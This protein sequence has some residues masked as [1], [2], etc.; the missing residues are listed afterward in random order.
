MDHGYI[1]PKGINI[2]ELLWADVQPNKIA[3][4]LLRAPATLSAQISTLTTMQGAASTS[5]QAPAS[6][7]ALHTQQLQNAAED[8]PRSVSDPGEQYAASHGIAIHMQAFIDKNTNNVLASIGVSADD[9]QGL[10]DAMNEKP[11]SFWDGM[12]RMM[13][14]DMF[15]SADPHLWRLVLGKRARFRYFESESGRSTKINAF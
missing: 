11:Q 1:V 15:G 2:L 6:L 10:W 14:P 3:G 12:V 8:T 4:M 5:T 9:E 13:E 7:F